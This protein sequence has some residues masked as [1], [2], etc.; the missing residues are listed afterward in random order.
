MFL[1]HTNKTKADGQST[2]YVYILKKRLGQR[3]WGGA[4]VRYMTLQSYLIINIKCH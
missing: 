1:K 3:Q 4:N 2:R